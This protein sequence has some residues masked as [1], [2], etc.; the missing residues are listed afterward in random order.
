MDRQVRGT[1]PSHHSA[2]YTKKRKHRKD[3]PNVGC[4][5]GQGVIHLVRKE[6][7]S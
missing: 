6:K 1:R 7:Q 5:G 2:N 3:N 4:F